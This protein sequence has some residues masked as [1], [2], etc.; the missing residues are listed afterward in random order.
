MAG[1]MAGGMAGRDGPGCIM[2]SFNFERCHGC[3]GRDCTAGFTNRIAWFDDR[4]IEWSQRSSVE[5]PQTSG[6]W[7]LIYFSIATKKTRTPY[8]GHERLSTDKGTFTHHRQTFLPHLGI[9]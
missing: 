1:G 7:I 8:R 4:M 2:L 3:H 6:G 9:C 5:V